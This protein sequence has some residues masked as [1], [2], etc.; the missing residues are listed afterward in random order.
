MV[1]GLIV[2]NELMSD[3][4]PLILR[5]RLHFLIYIFFLIFLILIS[6]RILDIVNI[7]KR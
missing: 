1:I 6:N 5:N 7:V 2:I 3:L 4:L